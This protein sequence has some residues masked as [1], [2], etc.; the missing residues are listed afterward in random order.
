MKNMEFILF[1]PGMSGIFWRSEEVPEEERYD[2]YL[3]LENGVGMLRLLL[4]EFEEAYQKLQERRSKKAELSIATGKLAY[5][6]LC[7][8]G[9]QR[10]RRNFPRFTIH[11]YLDPQ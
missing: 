5:P 9:R 3:Q 6:Y 4:N 2:G 7:P 10:W 1:M 8:D 11:V